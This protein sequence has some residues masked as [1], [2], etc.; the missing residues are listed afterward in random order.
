VGCVECVDVAFAAQGERRADRHGAR[1]TQPAALQ[2]QLHQCAPGSA[3]PVAE[4]VDRL[5]LSVRYGHSDD[6]VS[7]RDVDVLDKVVEQCRNIL[8]RWWHIRGVQW[9]GV[10]GSCADPVLDRPHK[11]RRWVV[12]HEDIVDFPDVRH[13]DGTRLRGDRESA[14]NGPDVPQRLNVRISRSLAVEREARLSTRESPR[15]RV[16]ALKRGRGR[17]LSAADQPLRW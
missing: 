14:L 4:R 16:N 10:H 7:G 17:A 9:S 15:R 13:G 8:R 3:V 1:G 12:A 2:H 5:K 6:R 11:P